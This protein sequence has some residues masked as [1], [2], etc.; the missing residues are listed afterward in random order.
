MI[1]LI[2]RGNESWP[3]LLVIFS[4]QLHNANRQITLDQARGSWNLHNNSQ[5]LVEN[6][7]CRIT[8]VLF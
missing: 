1:V 3:G 5:S 4:L 6:D 7:F 8:F 2:Q